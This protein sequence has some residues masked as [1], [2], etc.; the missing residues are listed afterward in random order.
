VA[1]YAIGDVQGCDRELGELLQRLKFAPDRDRVWFVGDLVNRGPDSLKVLRRVR[2]LG[3]AA[4]VC[5]AI[6]IWRF[7]WEE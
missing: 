3:A 5:I 6:A 1:V 4:T 2:S 7:R